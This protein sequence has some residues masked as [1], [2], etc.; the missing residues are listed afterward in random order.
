MSTGN[1]P[2]ALVLIQRS[3]YSHIPPGSV[4][5]VFK[6]CEPHEDAFEVVCED[7]ENPI[8]KKRE[9]VTISLKPQDVIGYFPKNR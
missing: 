6:F 2:L 7:I 8:T 3:D 1:P 5:K 4:G 9:T